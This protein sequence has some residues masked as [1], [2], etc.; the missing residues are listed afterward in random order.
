MERVDQAASF[1]SGATPVSLVKPLPC[2]G[3]PF[4]LLAMDLVGP[5]ERTQR[6]HKY[7]LTAMCLFSK[8]PEA[9][10]LKRVDRESVTEALM[11]I[12]SRHG[13]PG[14]VL[15]DQGSVFMSGVF[16]KVCH[17][18]G[19]SK[20]RTSPYHPQSD[21]AIEHWH[22]CLKGMIVKAQVC[23]R[24][25]DTFLKYV[26]LAYQNTPH[27]VTGFSPFDLLHAGKVQGPL[28]MLRDSWFQ[29]EWLPVNLCEWYTDAKTKLAEMSLIVTER[30]AKAKARMKDVYDRNAKANQVNLS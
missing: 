11:E 19:I 22:S 29:K 9:F 6:G 7:I 27:V 23:K 30:E 24:D 10:P 15:T 28:K 17:T 18:L 5:L 16:K 25:W 14:T 26:L 1:Q 4:E 3:Q 2:V 12:I 21:G 8:Y 20:I 13:L